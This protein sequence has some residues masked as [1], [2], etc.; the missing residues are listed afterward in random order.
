MNLKFALMKVI[1]ADN[2]CEFMF[3]YSLLQLFVCCL[4][5]NFNF[6][7][8]IFINKGSLKI[9]CVDTFDYSGR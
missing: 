3:Q 2:L 9:L 5:V 6:K 7:N 1:L 4:H 8:H